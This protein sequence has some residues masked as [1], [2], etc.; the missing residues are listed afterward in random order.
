M[1]NPKPLWQ[2]SFFEEQKQ[3]ALKRE[4]ENYP[5][6][7]LLTEF[8]DEFREKNNLLAILTNKKNNHS[9]IDYTKISE[10]EILVSFITGRFYSEINNSSPI[11]DKLSDFV[12]IVLQHCEAFF[13]KMKD[14]E[15]LLSYLN[16][17]IST[18]EIGYIPQ[19][20]CILL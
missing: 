17:N 1:S 9:N 11:T 12:L 13:K 10:A 18:L 7:F 5:I 3:Q 19:K 2:A 14:E 6:F 16:I 4:R 20:C 8:Q 15:D